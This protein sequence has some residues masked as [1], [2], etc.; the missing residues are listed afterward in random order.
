MSEIITGV[1]VLLGY[2]A[3]AKSG[4]LR[5]DPEVARDCATACIDA[6][7]SLQ[8]VRANMARQTKLLPLGDF[9]CGHDLA[10]ILSEVT[11]QYCD[12]LDEHILCLAAIHDMVGA[13]VTD[14]LTTDEQTSAALARI[15]G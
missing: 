10:T 9:D 4:D 11:Q 14:T 13:Q 1:D 3:L 15:G 12:R 5:L 8:E 2:A 7:N 6:M